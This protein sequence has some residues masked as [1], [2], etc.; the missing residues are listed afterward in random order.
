MGEKHNQLECKHVRDSILN[1]LGRQCGSSFDGGFDT[2]AF[3][4]P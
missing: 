4:I 3:D 2:Y 1:L